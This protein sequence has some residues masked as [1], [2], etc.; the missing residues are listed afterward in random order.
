MIS[1]VNPED[2]E[3]GDP[4]GVSEPADVTGE[5]GV[6]F[7]LLFGVSEKDDDVNGVVE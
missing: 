3:K 6:E 1:D 5:D 2:D 7:S 4:V